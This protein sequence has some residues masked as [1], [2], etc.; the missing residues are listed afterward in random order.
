[1]HNKI[2]GDSSEI[3]FINPETLL[4][5]LQK[6][7]SGHVAE[8]SS[9]EIEFKAYDT[10]PL[11]GAIIPEG[12]PECC[13]SHSNI[14]KSLVK[15]I[16]E[17]PNCCIPHKRVIGTHWFDKA[18]YMYVPIKVMNTFAFTMDCIKRNLDDP[19]WHKKI[20]DYIDVTIRSFGQLPQGYG[21]PVG[22]NYYTSLVINNLPLIDELPVEKHE[23][24]L[25][26]FAKYTGSKQDKKSIDID[27]LVTIYQEWLKIFPFEIP[28]LTHIKKYFE[29]SIPILKGP[30][31]TNIY[32]GIT[33]F[34]IKS[35]K[36]LIDFLK[37][38]TNKIFQEL[39]ALKMHE[40]GLLT[41]T[42]ETELKLLMANRRIEIEQLKFSRSN[43]LSSYLKLLKKW[44]KGERQFV[45]DLRV[46]LNDHYSDEQFLSTI[47][48]GILTLQK[49]D[50]N[51]P[52]I[53]NIRNNGSNKETSVR[54]WFKNFLTARYIG[55]TIPAEEQNGVGYMDLKFYHPEMPDKIIEFKGWWNYDKKNIAK[56]VTNYLTDFE[57]HAYI[58]MINHLPQKN[59]I[60]DYQK[61]LK[62]SAMNYQI[63]SWRQHKIPNTDFS[64]YSSEHQFLGKTK[65]LYHFI[66]NVFF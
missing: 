45:S 13:E 25:T 17:F 3:C 55:A 65:K 66:F 33:S 11:D 29:N 51:E 63:D 12:F 6:S 42:K 50:T 62:N 31:D 2:T 47:A 23:A 39:N 28:Y 7:A 4:R 19:Q 14:Y 61:L 30:G 40:K 27:A 38:T 32:T 15:V 5:A 57:D 43:D 8:I 21:G 18:N 16:S 54:Y 36:E 26:I 44:L 20:A 10:F 60:V 35:K 59:I 56:Q 48:D 34:S 46:L 58:V 64:Y 41:V 37:E 1:M 22:L 49:N 24:I 53:V 52:C 9:K